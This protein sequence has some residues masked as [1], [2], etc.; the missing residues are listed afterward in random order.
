MP[1]LH[2][3]PVIHHAWSRNT[4]AAVKPSL[5]TCE[6]VLTEAFLLLE[7]GN[8]GDPGD[9]LDMVERGVVIP[10]FRI[11]ENTARIRKLM[12]KYRD[13]P[14]SLADACLVVMSEQHEDAR[15][16]TL[17]SHFRVYRRHG[18]N[19]IPVLMPDDC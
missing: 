17:D 10:S 18:R 11:T 14:M 3:F 5:Y 4:I 15:V 9:L 16:L 2:R 1:Y 8:G 6:A 13:I 7:Q 19:V 12:A